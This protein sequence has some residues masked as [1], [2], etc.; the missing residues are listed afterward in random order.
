[1]FSSA[2]ITGKQSSFFRR[3]G[4]GVDMLPEERETERLVHF[5]NKSFGLGL[6]FG[7]GTNQ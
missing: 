4:D 6:E 7:P 1:M 5:L 2:Y 3:G